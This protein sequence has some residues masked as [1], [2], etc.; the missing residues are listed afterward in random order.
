MADVSSDFES[1]KR[2]VGLVSIFPVKVL[3]D[4]IY[5]LIGLL[6]HPAKSNSFQEYLVE[7]AEEN[8]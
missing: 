2:E 4:L 7:L 3:K 1:L 6:L 5:R 8:R